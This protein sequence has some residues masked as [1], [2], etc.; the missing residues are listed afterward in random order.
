[1]QAR[2]VF[3]FSRKVKLSIIRAEKALDVLNIVKKLC[4]KAIK[5]QE[6]TF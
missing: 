6:Q 4:S 1:M 5:I 3:T 2:S